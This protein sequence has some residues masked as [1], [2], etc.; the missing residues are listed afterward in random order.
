MSDG[1]LYLLPRRPD[2]RLPQRGDFVCFGGERGV[3]QQ[4]ARRPEGGPIALLVRLVGG[5]RAGMC[6]VVPHTEASTTPVPLDVLCD[7]EAEVAE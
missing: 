2:D 6:T 5:P 1:N 4:H 3:V 7:L